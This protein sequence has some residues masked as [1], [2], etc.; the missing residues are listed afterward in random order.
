M[1]HRSLRLCAS[2]LVLSTCGLS[3]AQDRSGA[4]FQVSDAACNKVVWS[5]V[6]LNAYPNI[7]FAC[8]EVLSRGGIYL[9]RVDCGVRRVA[10]GGREVTVQCDRGV[11]IALTLPEG[12]QLQVADRSVAA[13]DLR[14]D[15]RLEFFIPQDE[16]VARLSSGTSSFEPMHRVAISPPPSLRTADAQIYDLPRTSSYWPIIGLTGIGL[17]LIAGYL[18]ARRQR[19]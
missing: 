16:L 15:D 5:E 13:R 14:P 6:A 17:I 4:A 3:V 19:R 7:Q 12:I 8:R 10:M 9:V 1:T 11:A 2:L 18:F